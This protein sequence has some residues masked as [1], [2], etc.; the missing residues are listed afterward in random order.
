VRWQR[1]ACVITCFF[2][3]QKKKKPSVW[4]G[5]SDAKEERGGGIDH[6]LSD[7]MG[8]SDESRLLV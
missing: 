3:S 1:D 2:V 7:L 6:A 5:L 8:A 4:E